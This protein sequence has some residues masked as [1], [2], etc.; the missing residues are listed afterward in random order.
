MD[1]RSQIKVRVSRQSSNLTKVDSEGE[2]E[3]G[4]KSDKN[5]KAPDHRQQILVLDLVNNVQSINSN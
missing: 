1:V 2:E 5:L 4:N 3:N